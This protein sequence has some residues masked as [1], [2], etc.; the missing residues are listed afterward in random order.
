M[1]VTTSL[2][3]TVLL[4]SLVVVPNFPQTMLIMFFISSGTAALDAMTDGFIAKRSK[5]SHDLAST[6]R[7]YCEF[8]RVCGRVFG[9]LLVGSVPHFHFLSAVAIST[10]PMAASIATMRL[11]DMNNTEPAHSNSQPNHIRGLLAHL[12]RRHFVCMLGLTLTLGLAP[13]FDAAEIFVLSDQFGLDQ[14]TINFVQSTVSTIAFL[15]GGVLFNLSCRHASLRS[16]LISA[17]V[18]GLVARLGTSYLLV[19]PPST[20]PKYSV[21]FA[22]VAFADVV[23]GYSVFASNVAN[24]MACPDGLEATAFALLT[25]VGNIGQLAGNNIG[26]VLTVWAGFSAT[27]Q[28]AFP[29]LQLVGAVVQCCLLPIQLTLA[30]AA[31]RSS[32]VNEVILKPAQD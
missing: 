31:M 21:V 10:L 12:N 26:T 23:L 29:W 32:K 20:V 17:L 9:S 24:S 18:L 7:V 6:Y 15:L 28:S 5:S 25:F 27:N 4:A 2:I 19:F 16:C 1:L 30:V 3:M 8:S 14:T 11:T 22:R 13:S